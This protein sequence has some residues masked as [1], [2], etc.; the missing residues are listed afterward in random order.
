MVK[1]VNWGKKYAIKKLKSLVAAKENAVY[2]GSNVLQNRERQR[3]GE[4][5]RKLFQ[6]VQMVASHAVVFR[7]LVLFS[8]EEV[9][10]VP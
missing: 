10:Q 7:G 4:R 8:G 3:T 5:Q 9:I 1:Y 2:K 6:T